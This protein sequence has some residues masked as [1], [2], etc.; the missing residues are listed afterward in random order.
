MTKR[1]LHKISLGVVLTAISMPILVVSSCETDSKTTKTRIEGISLKP[2]TKMNTIT[3]E[4]LDHA[5]LLCTTID[6][7]FSGITKQNLNI[8]F[9][10]KKKQ[11]VPT[12]MGA[13]V[14]VAKKGYVFENNELTLTSNIFNIT[15]SKPKNSGS[16]KPDKNK[17]KSEVEKPK[18]ETVDKTIIAPKPD[19]KPELP[20]NPKVEVI[21]KQPTTQIPEPDFVIEVV[22]QS[23]ENTKP[24][25]TVQ[26]PESPKV[27]VIPQSPKN[28]EPEVTTQLPETPKVDIIPE[29]PTTQNPKNDSI[30]ST[31][32]AIKELTRDHVLELGWNVLTDVTIEM[33]Q[34]N[35]LNIEIIGES[36]FEGSN[37]KNIQ[38][39]NSVKHVKERAFINCKLSNIILP[40]GIEKI[41]SEAFKECGLTQLKIPNSLIWIDDQAFYGNYIT[42]VLFPPNVQI[43]GSESFANNK[44]TLW[45]SLGGKP[46]YQKNSFANQNK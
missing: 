12:G 35:N 1:I 44:I 36:A 13:I 34:E 5:P 32:V 28:T 17:D 23:P 16:T 40:N 39:P 8:S 38:L 42:Q 19:K 10:A 21:P 18:I 26:L 30:G 20:E 46:E 3:Q 15:S 37:L 9:E 11:D 6:L 4:M 2:V 33:F 27:E 7:V 14:L 29:Q 25:V 31:N 43:I 24:G 45:R 22:P 41:G